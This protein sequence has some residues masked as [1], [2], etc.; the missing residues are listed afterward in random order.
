MMQIKICSTIEDFQGLKEDWKY[1][2]SQSGS[3]LFLDWLW[4]FS[5]WKNYYQFYKSASLFILTVYDNSKCVA[6][7]PFFIEPVFFLG[8]RYRVLRFLASK[9]ESLGLDILLDKAYEEQIINELAD[10]LFKN[11]N[12]WDYAMIS[13]V[14]PDSFIRKFAEKNNFIFKEKQGIY[15]EVDLQTG[16]ENY[17]E[18]LQPRMRTKIRKMIKEAGS[19]KLSIALADQSNIEESFLSLVELHQKRWEKDRESGAFGGGKK[20]SYGFL[21]D[22]LQEYCRQDKIRIYNLIKDDKF[23]GQQ[24]YFVNNNTLYLFQEGYK[25]EADIMYP[26]NILRALLM[27][28]LAEQN[29]YIYNFMSGW[30][31]HK[32]SWGGQKKDMYYIRFAHF[33]PKN[34]F[35]FYFYPWVEKIKG[36]WRGLIFRLKI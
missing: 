12:K 1:L 19:N 35:Y 15:S 17:L 29:K 36:K 11:K 34:K 8:I 30:T 14:E 18:Q 16:W 10:F 23:L 13:S 26:G 31:F 6:I 3:F 20:Y 7:A 27:K 33:H 9:K 25:W 28:N 24:L 22:I 32:K 4:M 5:W 2:H 21:Q